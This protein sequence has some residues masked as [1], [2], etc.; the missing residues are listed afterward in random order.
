MNIMETDSVKRLLN[1]IQSLETPE[2]YRLFFEDICTMREIQDMA[3]RLEVAVLLREGKNYQEIAE[4]TSV[5]SATISRVNR[6]LLYGGGGYRMALDK[7]EET[8]GNE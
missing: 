1:I 7:Y 6:C 3:Q 5:S 2:E 4:Q 8:V